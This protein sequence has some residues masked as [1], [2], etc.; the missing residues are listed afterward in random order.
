MSAPLDRGPNPFDCDR[1]AEADAIRLLGP[2]GLE[3]DP[4]RLH[5]AGRDEADRRA[6]PPVHNLPRRRGARGWSS[7][8]V[9]GHPPRVLS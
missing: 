9:R 3:V 1:R 5:Q 6:G 2:R 8:R 7:D 4:V